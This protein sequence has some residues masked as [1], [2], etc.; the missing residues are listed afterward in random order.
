MHS[1]DLAWLVTVRLVLSAVVFA[2]IEGVTHAMGH[3]VLWWAAAL[4][5]LVLVFGG[6]LVIDSD[7]WTD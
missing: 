7:W 6:W 5:S 4:I 2:V 1:G 3:H